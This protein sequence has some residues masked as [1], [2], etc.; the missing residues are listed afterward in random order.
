M[1]VF[2]KETTL[3]KIDRL[4]KEMMDKGRR[5]RRVLVPH[6]LTRDLPSRY[7]Q[8]AVMPPLDFFNPFSSQ[9]KVSFHHI[10]VEM[11]PAYVSNIT[12]EADAPVTERVIQEIKDADVKRRDIDYI[13]LDRVEYSLLRNEA[14]GHAF[15][16]TRTP[17]S[18]TV[19]TLFGVRI[20]VEGSEKL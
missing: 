11:V 12:V 13:E 18:G 19:E 7:R 14:L 17:G 16:R 8:Y 15:D 1:K 3:D 20:E 5:P 4:V 9:S 6:S 10:Q 2:Y